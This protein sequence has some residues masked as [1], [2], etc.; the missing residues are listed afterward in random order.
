MILSGSKIDQNGAG[1][2][3]TLG[4]IVVG[5]NIWICWANNFFLMTRS[6]SLSI[7]DSTLG[8]F[9]ACFSFPVLSKASVKNLSSKA[10]HLWLVKD[11]SKT[12]QVILDFFKIWSDCRTIIISRIISLVP[13][14]HQ[15][16][17]ESKGKKDKSHCSSS[18]SSG[19]SRR[20]GCNLIRDAL[21]LK[22]RQ[23]VNGNFYLHFH[24]L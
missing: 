16:F 23:V 7:E 10:Q 18:G 8:S 14:F 5:L 15:C 24:P 17:N 21:G 20:V 11:S 1:D 19:S 13:T 6:S 12:C 2:A 3:G 4:N 22:M 9:S